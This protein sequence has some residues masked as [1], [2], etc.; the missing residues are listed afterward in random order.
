MIEHEV[1]SALY[2]PVYVLG[3]PLKV[4]LKTILAHIAFCF[5]FILLFNKRL[6][7]IVCLLISLVIASVS[8]F[9]ILVYLR[10]QYKL[11]GEHWR[12]SVK[13]REEIPFAKLYKDTRAF[14]PEVKK[15]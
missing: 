10:R 4:L 1:F 9:A 12:E 3:V 6:S 15:D 13:F 14:L 5:V 7:L 8:F 11:E 2:E